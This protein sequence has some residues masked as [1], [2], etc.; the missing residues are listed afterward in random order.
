ML[1]ARDEK[2]MMDWITSIRRQK[3]Q[4]SPNWFGVDLSTL[5]EKKDNEYTNPSH[6]KALERFQQYLTDNSIET[7]TKDSSLTVSIEI[8][9]DSESNLVL[10]DNDETAKFAIKHA[11]V[12]KL[13]EKLTDIKLTNTPYI[14]AFLL[15]FHSFT[16]PTTLLA[17][18][19]HL[20]KTNVPQ[21][22]EELSVLPPIL[23]RVIQVLKKWIDTNFFD[24]LD[25]PLL[26]TQLL[27]FL[28]THL[29][30]TDVPKFKTSGEGIKN[31]V[32]RKVNFLFV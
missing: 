26:T 11:T 28:E 7:T 12:S 20:W 25:S 21:N 19:I 24:F 4:Y 18:L 2:E 23:T 32:N 27:T 14:E 8:E 17:T 13:I 1:L 30:G 31:S 29:I 16:T 9:P 10:A 15:T 22:T 3:Y 5:K 6:Q